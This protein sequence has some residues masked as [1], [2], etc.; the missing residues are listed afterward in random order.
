MIIIIKYFERYFLLFNNKGWLFY[1]TDR[2]LARYQV[3][4]QLMLN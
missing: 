1:K 3:I 2:S 4:C